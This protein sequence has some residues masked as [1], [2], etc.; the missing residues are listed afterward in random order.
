MT[1]VPVTESGVNPSPAGSTTPARPVPALCQCEEVGRLCDHCCDES[2]TAWKIEQ[3][4]AHVDDQ[5]AAEL[6]AAADADSLP[7]Q[8]D[9]SD[10]AELHAWRL[11]QDAREHLDRADLG[12]A[13]LVDHSVAF[14]RSWPTAAGEM[15]ARH[16]ESLALR[17][18]LTDST[19]PEEYDSRAEVLDAE[20]RQA[21]E[22]VAY[23]EGKAA[24]LA[25]CQRRHGQAPAAWED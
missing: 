9:E 8:P 17:L 3:A 20:A 11:E 21:W 22:D 16:L 12:L 1:I 2:F 6:R 7:E 13:E 19:T 24:A 15:I 25:E 5:A 23:E 10:L 18:R 4:V 14:F